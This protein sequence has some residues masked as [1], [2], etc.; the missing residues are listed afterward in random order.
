VLLQ[1]PSSLSDKM[2]ALSRQFLG[3]GSASDLHVGTP[4]SQDTGILL[5]RKAKSELDL[6][7][8][9]RMTASYS[10][11]QTM[12]LEDSQKGTSSTAAIEPVPVILNPGIECDAFIAL[13][14]LGTLVARKKGR[15]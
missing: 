5:S 12:E 10:I 1:R 9:E 15:E 4:P 7:N 11:L 8:M 14:E 2:A 13:Q 6:A 3:T